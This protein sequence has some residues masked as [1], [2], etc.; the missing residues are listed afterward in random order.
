MVSGMGTQGH[1][2]RIITKSIVKVDG[3]Q[4]KD[5]LPNTAKRKKSS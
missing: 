2:K 5:R 1:K 4:R 3:I